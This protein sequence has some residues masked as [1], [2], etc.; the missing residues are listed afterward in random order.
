MLRPVTMRE[1][2]NGP[3]PGKEARVRNGFTLIELLVVVAIIAILASLLLPALANA[4]QKAHRIKCVSI[5]KQIGLGI[6]MYTDDNDDTLPGPV[7]AGVRVNYDITSS[8]ELIFYLATYLGQPE[9]SK[10]MI[11]ADYFEKLDVPAPEEIEAITPV[12]GGV[13]MC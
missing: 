8:Q 1:I 7:L 9:P 13:K 2:G 12:S 5:L 3:C 6:H 4:K 11:V 10:K